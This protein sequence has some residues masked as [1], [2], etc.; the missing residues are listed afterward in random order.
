MMPRLTVLKRA[1]GYILL[2]WY[3]CQ[4]SRTNCQRP[5][6]EFTSSLTDQRMPKMADLIRCRVSCGWKRPKIEIKTPLLPDMILIVVHLVA[7]FAEH[8]GFVTV[9]CLNFSFIT[10]GTPHHA[11]MYLLIPE[12]TQL[13]TFSPNLNILSPLNIFSPILHIYSPNRRIYVQFFNF[14][15]WLWLL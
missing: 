8:G 4:M 14:Y 15:S 13:H 5:R 12:L 1:M 2:R 9:G 10:C 7:I 11:G 6:T 3:A